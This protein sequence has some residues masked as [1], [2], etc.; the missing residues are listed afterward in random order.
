MNT[1]LSRCAATLVVLL[2]TVSVTAE[3]APAMT[4]GNGD[5][6]WI[7]VDGVTRDE[8]VLTFSEVNIDG[9]G[10]LVIHPFEDGKPNGDKYVA[11]TYLTDGKN[12]DVDI[13]VYKGLSSG[14]MFIVMLHR[15]VNE[16][17]VL[18]FVFVNDTAV[19]DTAVFEG[20]KMI[21]HAIPAP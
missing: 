7:V 5:K 21:G 16:N 2:F 19:M 3:E 9:N 1:L 20:S 15:D 12:S 10:W 6:N 17:K 8:S 11:S 14:E 18:D 4:M 13:E